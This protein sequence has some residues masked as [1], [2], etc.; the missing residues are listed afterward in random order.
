MNVESIRDSLLYRILGLS[1]L[2][3][4]VALIA[5]GLCFVAFRPWGLDL[6]AASALAGALFGGGAVLLG[7]WISRVNSGRQNRLEIE[8]RRIK[9][10]ALI[11]AELV[12]VATSLIHAKKLMDAAIG[13]ATTQGSV[14]TQIDLS[15]YRPNAMSYTD[16]L[17]TELL[18]LD[19][20]SIDALATLRS[21][22][23]ITLQE[24]D[25]ISAGAN[26]GLLKATSLSN[27]LGH[28]MSVLANTFERIAPAR[29]LQFSGQLPEL[30]TNILKRA[31]QPHKKQPQ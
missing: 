20:Q 29:K 5:C 27:A 14:P 24:M 18:L 19:R 13:S 9:I 30:V 26:F 6:S 17:G 2:V 15:R 1:D 22:L 7:N 12:G 16:S 21:N 8:E 25:E 10:E 28:D 23:A 31:A 11:A 3:L 4:F